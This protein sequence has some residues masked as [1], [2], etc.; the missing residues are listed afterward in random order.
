MGKLTIIFIFCSGLIFGQLPEANRRVLSYAITHEGQKVGDGICGSLIKAALAENNKNW[1]REY[2]QKRG[3]IQFGNKLSKKDSIIPGDIIE[4]VD[5]IAQDFSA[6]CHGGIV[7]EIFPDGRIVVLDQNNGDRQ[8]KKNKVDAWV[9]DRSKII[10][11]KLIFYR[12]I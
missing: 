12:P 10:S 9:L 3:E 4:F 1:K 7:K 11:G 5:V 6:Y 8:G 2:P